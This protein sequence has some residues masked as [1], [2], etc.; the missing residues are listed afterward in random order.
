MLKPP[1]VEGPE[2]MVTAPL[3]LHKRSPLTRAWISLVLISLPLMFFIW[4]KKVGWLWDE[5]R[6]LNKNTPWDVTYAIVARSKRAPWLL[7]RM[8]YEI[9]YIHNVVWA[10]VC[11]WSILIWC[12]ALCFVVIGFHSLCNSCF[13]MKILF[14]IQFESI[15]CID[16]NT[17]VW[18]KYAIL[19]EV[20]SMSRP[21]RH[22]ILLI[23]KIFS[24]PQ[25]SHLVA[26]IKYLYTE[27]FFLKRLIKSKNGHA[28]RFVLQ[29]KATSSL[30]QYIILLMFVCL[31]II[32]QGVACMFSLL[33]EKNWVI[34]W[35]TLSLYFVTLMVTYNNI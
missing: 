8:K 4:Q 28:L 23:L 14:S 10:Y 16:F 24:T 11:W 1:R 6:V 15:T 25:F 13:M 9:R 27:F 31:T 12:I 2:T 26:A 34:L 5:L 32:P 29:I 33:F 7:H 20:L 30:N 21:N 19:L 17:I 3:P 35:K 18:R 22:Q